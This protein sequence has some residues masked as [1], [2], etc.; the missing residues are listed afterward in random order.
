MYNSSV[1]L[2]A[3]CGGEEG[4]LAG[5]PR[6]PARDF[7]PCTPFV[8]VY[9]VLPSLIALGL[10]STRIIR[11]L[12]SATYGNLKRTLNVSIVSMVLFV[13]TAILAGNIE[14]RYYHIKEIHHVLRNSRLDAIRKRPVRSR[15]QV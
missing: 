3:A 12:N 9:R 7:V 1:F 6:A 15:K 8:R 2:L 13:A 14:K 11:L 5:T 10:V 4:E